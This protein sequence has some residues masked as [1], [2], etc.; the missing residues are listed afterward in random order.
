MIQLL[1]VFTTPM[2]FFINKCFISHQCNPSFASMI[3]KQVLTTVLH[4][5]RKILI[6]L[7]FLLDS[8][9]HSAR[10]ASHQVK[11]KV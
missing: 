9:K 8:V 1:I 3:N 7:N 6:G 5:K 10:A 11:E 2:F 4:T